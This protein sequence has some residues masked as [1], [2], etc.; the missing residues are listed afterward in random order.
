MSLLADILGNASSGGIVGLIGGI[1]GGV[2][3]YFQSKADRAFK[4]EEMKLTATLNAAKTAGDI[5]LAREAGAA[6]AFTTS[7]K[8]D[9]ATQSSGWVSN[10]RGFTR[11]GLTWFFTIALF[12]IISVSVFAPT[13]LLDAPPLLEFGVTMITDTTGMMIAW[14]FG[15]RQI[16]RQTRSWGNSAASASVK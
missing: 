15:S 2:L 5:A 6:S 13:W 12:T 1:T 9:L 10:L 14:W 11:P 16:E 4:L 8:A 7:Q 3:N